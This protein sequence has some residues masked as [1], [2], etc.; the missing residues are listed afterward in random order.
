LIGLILL[1]LKL[2][3]GEKRVLENRKASTTPF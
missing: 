2:V 3:I 1:S